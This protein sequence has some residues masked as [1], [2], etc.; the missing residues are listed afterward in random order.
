MAI[1]ALGI[2]VVGIRGKVGGVVFSAN[3]SGPYAKAWARGSNPITARQSTQR[4]FLAK[5]PSLWRALTDAQR[6]AWDVFAA[7]PAQDLINPLGETISISGFGWFCKI[8]IRL[9]VIDRSARTAVPTQSRPS[10]PTIT[11]FQMPFD[12]AQTAFVQYA[13][14]EFDPDFDLI[15]EI[16]QAPSI[17]RVAPPSVF[18]EFLTLQNPNDTQA[19][20]PAQYVRRLG[21]G[22]VA[23]RGFARLYRQTTDGLRS[24][25]GAATFIADDAPNYSLTALDYNGTTDYALRGADLT[26][27][28]NSKTITEFGWFKIDGGDGTDRYIRNNSG[29]RWAV[30][31]GVDNRMRFDG[32]TTAPAAAYAIRSTNTYLAGSGWHSYAF[33]VD[34]AV[35][36]VKLWIDG[37]EET[38]IELALVTD[39]VTD[40]TAIDH[41]VGADV[42]GANFWDGCLTAIWSSIDTALDWDDLAIRRA[43]ISPTNLP[44]YLGSEGQL[45]TGT[46]P[47]I[48][49]PDGNASNNLGSGGNFTNQS[50]TSLCSDDP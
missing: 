43:F 22:N 46:P 36:I 21:V 45:P 5:M 29:G 11:D 26:G 12:Q 34:T 28:A 37:V 4:S 25:A 2:T 39:A 10:A 49:L 35:P 20:F 18:A 44:L 15:L 14:A 40:V 42:A 17:G 31:I 33:S 23:L 48:Y 27:A 6:T 38:I 50:G 13:S 24:A 32:L 3:K 16:A 41:S 19:G 30:R 1:I 47:I 8:N 7:L 9:L